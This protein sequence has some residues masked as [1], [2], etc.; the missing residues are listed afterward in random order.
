MLRSHAGSR[1]DGAGREGESKGSGSSAK[2]SDH[3]DVRFWFEA[4]FEDLRGEAGEDVGRPHAKYPYTLICGLLPIS[5]WF[6][7]SI[8][9]FSCTH[10]RGLNDAGQVHKY[11]S[12]RYY[13]HRTETIFS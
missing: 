8:L 6:Y 2:D 9:A 1:H 4:L 10:T 7:L 3:V 5:D 12:A 11:L 13:Y